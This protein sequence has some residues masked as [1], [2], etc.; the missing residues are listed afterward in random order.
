MFGNDG[1]LCSETSPCLTIS[2]VLS[3]FTNTLLIYIIQCT[4]VTGVGNIE[5]SDVIIGARILNEISDSVIISQDSSITV[6]DGIFTINRGKLNINNISILHNSDS[7]GRFI[8]I[9]GLGG[10]LE[11][12]SCI[13]YGSSLS[14]SLSVSGY[15][16]ILVEVTESGNGNNE[17]TIT[18]DNVIFSNISFSNDKILEVDGIISISINNCDFENISSGGSGSCINV[19]KVKELNIISSKF[20]NINSTGDGGSIYF[21]LESLRLIII[22]SEFIS[23]SCINGHGGAIGYESYDGTYILLSEDEFSENR[24]G[25][26]K[27]GNDYCDVCTDNSSL[28]LYGFSTFVSIR[29]NSESNKFYH[30]GA[31]FALDFFLSDVCSSGYPFILVDLNE[32]TDE[33]NCGD[34]FARCKTFE[35]GMNNI[36]TTRKKLVIN[37]GEYDF[38]YITLNSKSISVEGMISDYFGDVNVDDIS[39]YPKI[40][41]NIID[42]INDLSVFYFIDTT[43]T[44]YY[45]QLFFSSDTYSSLY[46][47]Y[48]FN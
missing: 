26:E 4:Y 17:G 27:N 30:N 3:T 35:Y 41:A 31:S 19:K 18:L 20:S 44:F 28:H 8:S 12:K 11:L 9:R 32:G 6:S 29:T 34:F 15:S 13:V 33:E 2:H 40:I 36:L 47:F 25:S 21:G 10:S 14:T 45:L 24:A 43:A 42:E 5:D 46:Y 23:C 48:S 38:S 16:F 1:N 37:I 39:T 7:K 22:M